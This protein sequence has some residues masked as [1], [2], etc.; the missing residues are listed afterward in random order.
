MRMEMQTS[1]SR[2]QVTL[3]MYGPVGPGRGETRKKSECVMTWVVS[4]WWNPGPPIHPDGQRGAVAKVGLEA[5]VGEWTTTIAGR[6]ENDILQ[7]CMA[8]VA[9]AHCGMVIACRGG[10]SQKTDG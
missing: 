7:G 8:Q 3:M 10:K 4:E 9:C 2:A 5:P 6:S 1:C